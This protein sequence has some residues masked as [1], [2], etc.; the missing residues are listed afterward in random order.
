MTADGTFRRDLYFRISAFPIRLPALRDRKED[1]PLL[2]ASALEDL[3]ADKTL[4]ASARALLLAHDWP[5]NVRELRNVVARAVLLA[6]RGTLWG[7]E[8]VPLVEV[9]RRYLEWCVRDAP[10]DRRVLAE[11]LGISERTLYRKL[12]GLGRSR[13]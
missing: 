3:G 6:D 5:G 7:D 9:E 13:P 8:V 2:V 4:S 11:R 12:A 10:S 1:L